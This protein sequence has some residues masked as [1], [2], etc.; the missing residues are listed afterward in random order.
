MPELEEKINAL[1]SSPDSLEQISTMANLL[2]S[3]GGLG[4]LG[5]LLSNSSDE[6]GESEPEPQSEVPDIPQSS[7][8]DR[9]EV[10]LKALRAYTGP[11]RHGHIDK[12][13]QI[14]KLSQMAKGA[15]KMFSVSGE[16]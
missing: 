15:I 7:H 10:L 6:E 9:R 16:K 1:L 4:M 13:L 5:S 12:A 8:S 3:G 11:E 2:A 14:L